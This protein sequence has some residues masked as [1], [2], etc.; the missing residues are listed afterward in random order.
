MNSPRVKPTFALTAADICTVIESCGKHGVFSLT[1]GSM[2]IM[3]AG[4]GP[5][6]TP[7]AEAPPVQLTHEQQDELAKMRAEAYIEQI[8]IENPVLYEDMLARGEIEDDHD[9][10]NP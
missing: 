1:L 6:P 10:E 3:F 4:R 9:G 5:V 2:K 7:L 8:K